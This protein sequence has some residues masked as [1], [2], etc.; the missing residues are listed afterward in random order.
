MAS[1]IYFGASVESVKIFN[2]FEDSL[3][4]CH[5][6]L[7]E[8]FW[9]LTAVAF[10][11]GGHGGFEILNKCVNLV[12]SS[13]NDDNCTEWSRVSG[14]SNNSTW[15]VEKSVWLVDFIVGAEFTCP[16]I[17]GKWV[18]ICDSWQVG[19][20]SGNGS[21]VVSRYWVEQDSQSHEKSNDVFHEDMFSINKKCW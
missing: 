12:S 20:L 9:Y 14:I 18:R 16:G 21:R 17:D 3:L 11:V 5:I 7:V 13:E 1:N 8:T 10:I 2:I 4:N 19:H 15:K 6:E